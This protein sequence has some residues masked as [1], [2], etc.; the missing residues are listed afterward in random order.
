MEE[1]EAIPASGKFGYRTNRHATGF[2]EIARE[3]GPLV[4][5]S[6]MKFSAAR[7]AGGDDCVP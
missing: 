3:K 4:T 6:H 5:I 1:F 2:L 7:R